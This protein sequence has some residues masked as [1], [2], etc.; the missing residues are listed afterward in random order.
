M[1][2]WIATVLISATMAC[3]STGGAPPSGE[4]GAEPGAPA[5]TV[6]PVRPQGLPPATLSPGVTPA[7]MRAKVA[8]FASVEL[9]FDESLLDADRKVVVAKLVEASRLLDEIFLRQVWRD[10]PAYAE[11]VA[12]AEGEGMDAARE[13]YEIMYGPWDRLEHDEPFLLVGPKPAG[14]GYYPSGVTK[15]EIEAWLE[16][17]PDDREAF[18]SYYTILARTREGLR[19]VPY[20]EAYADRLG[21]A[22]ALLRK[23]AEHAGNESL[24]SFLRSRANAFETNDYYASEVAWMNLEGNLIEPTIGPYEV[25]EDE[26][27]GWKAA[28]ESFVTIKDP[29]ASAELETLVSH[30]PDLE[31]ALPMDDEYKDLERSFASP[32]SVVDVIYTA[33]DTRAGV[34][35]LAFNLPNDPRVSREHGTKKVMLRN[36]IDAKFEKI[37]APIGARVLEA[38]LADDLEAKA[39]TTSVVMH[40]LA[41]GLGP[42]IVHGTDRSVSETLGPSYSAIEEAKADVVGVLSLVELVGEGAFSSEFERQVYVSGVASLFRCV[43]FGTGGAHGKGCAVQMNALLDAGAVT[44]GEDGRFAIDFDAIHGA[45]RDL[46]ERLLTIEATGDAEAA[47]AL[48]EAMGSVPPAGVEALDRLDDV[49]VDIRPIYAVEEA[50]EAWAAPSGS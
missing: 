50:M 45:Y 35:T 11:Q 14:A 36:V 22:A 47:A 25:Y 32:L 40:E 7:D 37:L 10:N 31:A 20:S 29:E 4:I 27:M 19:A 2:R 13:Y 6:A 33:G 41:H 5:D 16:K 26:L 18:T 48:L 1:K 28:F 24:A 38:S 39:F 43:R 12:R 17:H 30:L 42:R 34:Q 8:Q 23:A 15:A 3:A 46:A 9:G 49:P 44:V 21:K